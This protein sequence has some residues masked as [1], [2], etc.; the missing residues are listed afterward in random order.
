MADLLLEAKTPSM[1]ALDSALRQGDQDSLT[2]SVAG[3][4]AEA[5][6]SCE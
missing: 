1:C 3:T 4:R 2:M 5:V 6:R